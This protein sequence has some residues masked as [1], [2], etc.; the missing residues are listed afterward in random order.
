MKRTTIYLDELLDR[1]LAQLAHRQERSKAELI[2]DVLGH[3]V[4]Q[5]ETKTVPDWVGMVSSGQG[6]LA[7][8]AEEVLGELLEQDYERMLEHAAKTKIDSQEVT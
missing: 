1:N 5:Q 2:R 7:E 6:D 3:Y 4:D 8:R